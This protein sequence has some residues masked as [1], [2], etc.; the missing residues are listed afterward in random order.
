MGRIKSK[1]VRRIGN[2]ILEASP[3]SFS[4]SFEQNK[5]SLGSNTLPS[6]RIRNMVAGYLSRVKKN[7]KK[8]IEN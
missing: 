1:L 8:L 3:E 4:K 6:K 5:K 7:E 2:Q